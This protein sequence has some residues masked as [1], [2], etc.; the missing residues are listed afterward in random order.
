MAAMTR[1]LLI[2][3]TRILFRSVVWNA[4]PSR[5]TNTAYA[6]NPTCPV[7]FILSLFSSA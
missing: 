4:K 3:T 1:K 2:T 7:F 5:C 6:L